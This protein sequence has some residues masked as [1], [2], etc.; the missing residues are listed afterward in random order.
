MQLVNLFHSGSQ[1]AYQYAELF[2]QN[3]RAMILDGVV[4]VSAPETANFLKGAAASDSVLKQ[5]FLWCGKQN[6]T[7]CPAAHQGQPLEDI[8]TKWLQRQTD[9]FAGT[10][11]AAVHNMLYH[12]DVDFPTLA[13][14]FYDG[15]FRNNYTVL[16][17]PPASPRANSAYNASSDLCQGSDSMSGL[18]PFGYLGSRL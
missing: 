18:V 8:W 15:A 5:F 11:R 12:P 4:S 16:A 17:G 3:I 14:D 9:V 13:I 1:L 2:P 6:A 7:V 10:I